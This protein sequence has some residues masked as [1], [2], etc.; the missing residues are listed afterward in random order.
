M[1]PGIIDSSDLADLMGKI[2][3]LSSD[4]AKLTK[5]LNDLRKK[6]DILRTIHTKS[7]KN[8]RELKKEVTDLRMNDGS[9]PPRPTATGAAS[10]KGSNDGSGSM[11]SPPSTPTAASKAGS[12]PKP[13]SNQDT[14]A[15]TNATNRKDEVDGDAAE[16]DVDDDDNNAPRPDPRLARLSRA[17]AE[18]ANGKVTH[19]LYEG[20]MM[21][22]STG[23]KK[24]WKK[25][26]VVFNNVTL[27]FYKSSDLLR[28]EFCF[29]T[30]RSNA[31]V[32][33]R[34]ETC[35]K[36]TSDDKQLV[37]KCETKEFARDL[38]SQINCKNRSK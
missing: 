21:R 27:S 29:D 8:S 31:V 23:F 12:A 30:K 2:E 1:V 17:A 7:S 5:D 26:Y 16:E 34:D 6:Y 24:N 22:K 9:S 32:V 19:V 35:F 36:I 3:L 28:L 20:P 11:S 25:A 4:N 38:V 18:K 33:P 14:D 15:G 10:A 37:L 13:P